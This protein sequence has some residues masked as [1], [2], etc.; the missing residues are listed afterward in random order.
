MTYDLDFIIKNGK[1]SSTIAGF[2]FVGLVYCKF[3]F[4]KTTLPELLKSNKLEQIVIDIFADREEKI[5][6]Y[7]LNDLIYFIL[8]IRDELELIEQLETKYLSSP[9][10]NKMISA[11][12]NE[13]DQFGIINTIDIL[14]GGDILKW[15]KVENLRYNVIFDKLYKNAIE[16]RIQKNLV[17]NGH[18]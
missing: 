7:T 4:V 11:G 6:E 3:K 5:K 14:A 2:D 15:R 17:K 13:L 9:P 10:D 8:W 12:I 1:R 18:S 16:T